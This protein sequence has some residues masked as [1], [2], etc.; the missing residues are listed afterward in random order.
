[1]CKYCTV[2]YPIYIYM[3]IYIYITQMWLK[4]LVYPYQCIL[5]NY[6][7]F[8]GQNLQEFRG[9]HRVLAATFWSVCWSDDRCIIL[10]FH[11]WLSSMISR[12]RI[13]T[14]LDCGLSDYCDGQR[15]Y[16]LNQERYFGYH[17]NS[18][19]VNTPL[20]NIAPSASNSL[21]SRMAIFRSHIY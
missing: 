10:K 8:N 5:A 15:L 18:G 11:W 4:E 20:S 17:L 19:C 2:Q 12:P 6:G 7:M 3:Y 13:K 14:V 1:M 9:H 16:W 21:R